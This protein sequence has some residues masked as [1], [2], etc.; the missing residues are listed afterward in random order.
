MLFISFQGANRIISGM[1]TER[2]S[3][4]CWLIMKAIIKGCLAGCLVH[5]ISN[6]MVHPWWMLAAILGQ[7]GNSPDHQLRPLNGF[8][9][10]ACE[11]AEITGRSE[12]TIP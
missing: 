4:A 9:G 6:M 12:A 8:F 10:K 11:S 3:I 1:I 5:I 2:H 7:E